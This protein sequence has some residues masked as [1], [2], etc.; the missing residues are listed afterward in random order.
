MWPLTQVIQVPENVGKPLK[1]LTALATHPSERSWR[2]TWTL[3]ILQRKDH[4]REKYPQDLHE[5]HMDNK[6]LTYPSR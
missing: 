4:W 2:P 6:T 1:G 3:A 5:S